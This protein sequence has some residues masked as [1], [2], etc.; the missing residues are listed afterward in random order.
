M[1]V[2][3]TNNKKS[4]II[5]IVKWLFIIA[6]CIIMLFPIFWTITGSFKTSTQLYSENP[7][8]LTMPNLQGFKNAIDIAN[9]GKLFINS[10]IVAVGTCVISLIFGSMAA[11]V[12]SRYNF[13]GV[14]LIPLFFL[15]FRMVPRITLLFPFFIMLNKVNL[16][17]THLGLILSHSSFTLP[18]AVWVMMSFFQDLPD[19]LEDAAKIDGCNLFQTYYKIFVP[20]VAPAFAALGILEF[21]FSWNEYLYAS[22]ITRSNALTLPTGISNLM[23]EHRVL[24]PELFSM[25]T[26]IAIP[27][28]L[29]VIFAQRYIVSGLSFGAVKG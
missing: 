3:K 17:D 7:V 27:A 4:L 22:V 13:V 28:L 26:V 24:W 25:A 8:W 6:I 11:Y 20:L 5:K 10:L 14:K 18:F 21:T 1:A 12:L 16:M 19:S 15:F 29:L 23:V 9:M 2:A